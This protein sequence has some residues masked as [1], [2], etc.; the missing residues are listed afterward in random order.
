MC[1]R[2]FINIGDKCI[3]VKV[4]ANAQLNYSGDGWMCK[5]GFINK[6]D[7]CLAV[8]IPA[9]AELNALGDDWVCGDGFEKAG[10]HC[11]EITSAELPAYLL[12]LQKLQSK[13]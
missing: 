7:K 12:L 3:V 4:P 1:N 11:E 8:Y 10:D 5:R 9:H 6:G 2:G 13:R